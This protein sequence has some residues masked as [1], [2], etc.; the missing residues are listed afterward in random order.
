MKNCPY[1]AEEVQDLAVVCKHCSRDLTPPATVVTPP[2]MSPVAAL[3][4]L[5]LIIGVSVAYTALVMRNGNPWKSGNSGDD[6]LMAWVMCQQFIEARL[7]SPSSAEFPVMDTEATIER[8][9]DSGHQPWPYRVRSYV[10]SQNGFGAMIRKGFEVD[11][12]LRTTAG[13]C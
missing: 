1:C 2:P 12:I 9:A 3:L 5:S 4:I 13:R 11:P 7:I 6:R 8:V 10:D